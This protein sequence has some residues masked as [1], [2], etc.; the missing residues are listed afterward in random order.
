MQ[1][2][3]KIDDSFGELKVIISLIWANGY[4][5]RF[6]TVFMDNTLMYKTKM[7]QI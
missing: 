1:I 4:F 3:E 5:V 6:V 7:M 2:E